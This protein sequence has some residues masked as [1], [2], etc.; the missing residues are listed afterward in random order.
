MR[1]T[2]K[3]GISRRLVGSAA[4]IALAA[5][6]VLG[7]ALPA[8]A[9]PGNMPTG[10]GTLTIHKYE[11]PSP[12]GGANNGGAALPSGTTSTWVP[13]TG[14]NFTIQRITNV[15]LATN[16]G[17]DLAAT[18]AANPA[19]ATSLGAATPV[20]TAPG[21]AVASTLPIGAYLVTEVASPAATLPNGSAANITMTAAPF[22]VTVPI[23][24]TNGTWNSDVHVYPKNSLTAVTKS[25]SAPSGN[26]LGSTLPWTI[27]VKIPY[28]T[29]GQSFTDFDVT[30]AL[31]TKLAYIAGSASATIGSTPVTLTDNTS[32][33]NVS[34]SPSDLSVLAAHQGQ[35]LTVTFNTTVIAAGAI[36]NQAS[37][38]VNDPSHTDPVISNQTTSYWGQIQITKHAEGDDTKTLQGAVFTVHETSADASSGANPVAV[39]GVTQFTTA[40]DGTVTIPGLFVSNDAGATK[41]YY[42]RE[43]T[44]PAGYN[45][46]P[47]PTSV[48]LT[49]NGNVGT[50]AQVKIANPQKPQFSLPL[51]GGDGTGTLMLLGGGLLLAAAGV[52]I[53]A[54]RRR[55]ARR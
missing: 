1:I 9:A 55:S 43:V 8:S 25:V 46:N 24:T 12:A 23:P 45:V 29:A 41:N 22:V 31:D 13:L 27:N 40:A 26:G 20:T 52:A 37:V 5:V 48:T 3:G 30:D 17:W 42:L 44:A 18:Y 21:G 4:A 15:D 10:D 36:G 7:A 50:P 6:G 35:T 16:A 51:T 53:V 33:Q 28:L 47:T 54:V 11:Q 39:S 14:V 49:S 2:K 34:L 19:S 32:G 38:F